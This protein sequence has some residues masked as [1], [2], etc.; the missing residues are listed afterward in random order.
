MRKVDFLIVGQGISGTFVSRELE[1]AGRSFIVIDKLNSSSASKVAAG[2]I[3]PVTGR[4]IVE[5]W[6]IG[7]LMEHALSAY[8]GL[9]AT[10]GITA[11]YSRK[12]VDFF[13]SPQMKLAFLQRLEETA[14]FL[15][16]P[17]SQNDHLDHFN[18]D[19][20]YGEI[21]PCYI[22]QL[23]EILGTWRNRLLQS[24]QVM[25][26]D[27]N[28]G[29]LE[30][31]ANGIG[32]RDISAQKVIFCEGIRAARNPWFKNLPFAFN[33]GE[34][35]L[36]RSEAIPPGLI[37][38]KGLML[39]PV[40]ENIFWV[41]SSYEWDFSDDQPSEA[42]RGKTELLLKHWLK[43]PFETIG[44]LAAIRPASIER[45]PFVGIHPH[46]PQLAILNGMGTKGCSLAPF[47][48][49]Q[50]IEL[51]TKNTPILK[52]ADVKRHSRILAMP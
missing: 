33:K 10:L 48:A 45:R 29:E 11:I 2:I 4:R 15:S 39:S 9:G 25:N 8:Q 36:I 52:E 51:L 37:Y 22:V 26:E 24:D 31:T 49:R 42:F 20:G 30:F 1:L 50:L 35:L 14:G 16:Q 47:F 18:Y 41:G 19:F 43:Q 38:K 23:G 40:A 12:L 32:Y 17:E 13:P 44:T 34:A 27:F 28:Y 46:L 21:S 3:N 7:V 5:T 6:M